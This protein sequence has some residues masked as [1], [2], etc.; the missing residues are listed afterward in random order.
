MEVGWL[1]ILPPLIAI[2]LAIATKK[3]VPSLLAGILVGAFIATDFSFAGIFTQTWSSFLEIIDPWYINI[4]LFLVILGFLVTLITAAGGSEAYADWASKHV[5]TR[6][7]A[8]IAT[9]ILGI[10]IFIDDYFNSLTVGTVM[11]PIT[12]QHRISRAKLAYIIDST[13][14]PV[15]ILVPVS[16]WVATLVGSI[17]ETGA[18]ADPFSVF[19]RTIPYN[20]YAWMALLMVVYLSLTDLEYGPMARHERLAQRTGNL[21]GGS[22]KAPVQYSITQVEVSSRGRL[23]DLILPVAS[24]VAATITAM[25]LIGYRDG[26]PA[27]ILESFGL[28]DAS[29]ALRWGGLAG[30][31]LSLAL[32]LPRR[33]ITVRQLGDCFIK[34]V[35]A[36]APALLILILA[37]T[38]SGIIGTL[39][40]GDFLAQFVQGRLP[41]FLLPAIIFLISGLMAFSTGTS[42]G[43]FGM[44][45]PIAVPIALLNAPGLTVPMIAAVIAGAVYGD[46]CCPI[47]DTT[48][49]SST[50]AGCAHMDHVNTQ[51]PYATTG[52]AVAFIGFIIAGV[53]QS[54]IISLLASAALLLGVMAVFHRI[55]A[56]KEDQTESPLAPI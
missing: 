31:A 7:G 16:S 9:L 38:I 45:I 30:L 29:E 52:A 49:L 8:Q 12:D 51:L 27:N 35:K 10:I 50:G 21:H 3:V 47:S 11:R 24:L 19:L 2:G 48:I 43:T 39:G 22:S 28:T 17:S 32:F 20:L 6:V 25:I 37:W 55:F 13:A 33:L 4:L 53:T 18:G 40:T 15:T 23:I 54:A 14:A 42:W 41:V 56:D 26:T 36:M 5:K 1:S 44:M 34:G 46:H